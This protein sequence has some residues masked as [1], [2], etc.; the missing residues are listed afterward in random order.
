MS[1]HKIEVEIPEGELCSIKYVRLCDLLGP[2]GCRHRE[3]PYRVLHL[4]T[5]RG[6]HRMT[7]CIE[8]YGIREAGE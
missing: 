6:R 8:K 4:Q 5:E 3:R 2:G 7:F 1:K